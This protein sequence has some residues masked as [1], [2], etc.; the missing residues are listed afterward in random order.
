MPRPPP[1]KKIFAAAAMKLAAAI[2]FLI[3]GGSIVRKIIVS[4]ERQ[5]F[6]DRQAEDRKHQKEIRLRQ[7]ELEAEKIRDEKEKRQA[8]LKIQQLR[9]AEA[10][11]KER[12]RK[13]RE[14]VAEFHALAGVGRA[15]LVSFVYPE[16][17]DAAK[18]MRLRGE[19]RL[20]LVR[21]APNDIGKSEYD[22]LWGKGQTV[23]EER[24]VFSG[25]GSPSISLKEK[26]GASK[27]AAWGEIVIDI[28]GRRFSGTYRYSA[29]TTG[30]LF[31][32]ETGLF[33]E[34]ISV[35]MLSPASSA[36][37]RIG[38]TVVAIDEKSAEGKDPSDLEDELFGLPETS[39]SISVFHPPK[40]HDIPLVQAANAK[41]GIIGVELSKRPDLPVIVN[42][43]DPRGPAAAAGI[44]EGDNILKVNNESVFGLTIDE[45]VDRISGPVGNIVRLSVRHFEILSVPRGTGRRSEQSIDVAISKLEQADRVADSPPSQSP[46]HSE[47]PSVKSSEV[48]SLSHEH[49][50]R[51]IRQYFAA[52]SSGSG[53]SR[54]SFW[55]QRAF[56]YESWK[57][58]EE[59]G[60]RFRAQERELPFRSFLVSS[61]NLRALDAR[62][63]DALVRVKHT[64]G[65]DAATA[66]TDE[67]NYFI[68]L[69][70]TSTGFLITRLSESPIPGWKLAEYRARISPPDFRQS[71][72]GGKL[73]S[74][75]QWNDRSEMIREVVLQ[76]RANFE[77]GR[78]KDNEDE[79]CEYFKQGIAKT[80]DEWVNNHVA[81]RL[82]GSAE[83]LLSGDALV[84]VTVYKNEQVLV[85]VLN[86]VSEPE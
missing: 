75:L 37:L 17:T 4:N 15:L 39:F 60:Q 70:G 79:P 78:T 48:S 5:R 68:R 76:D 49:A 54:D 27:E 19:R 3:A 67:S 11:L 29:G 42:S 35:L 82:E 45:V 72:P 77:K 58:L 2:F 64:L 6:E 85:K 56:F 69:E 16:T 63:F 73:F 34:I 84:A 55:A 74:E 31:K 21:K 44:H 51:F 52:A 43:V 14:A 61:I 28:T 33:P 66:K 46:G 36:G 10:A 80:R 86:R 38:D 30:L 20:L 26:P 40:L 47:T 23:L 62:S 25:D 57:T 81:I 32:R 7:D 9:T 53:K 13:E 8:E 65:K 83:R 59:V 71:Q 22:L 24:V 12:E 18:V 50:E 1:A 41:F